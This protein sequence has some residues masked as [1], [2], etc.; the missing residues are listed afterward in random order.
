MYNMFEKHYTSDLKIKTL[1]IQ[2][3]DKMRGIKQK[4][5]NEHRIGMRFASKKWQKMG[6]TQ[7]KE[8]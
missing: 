8:R 6:K 3:M 2:V 5:L 1:E 7:H 4:L